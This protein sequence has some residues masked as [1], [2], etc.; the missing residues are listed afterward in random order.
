MVEI[1]KNTLYLTSA[2]TFQKILAFFYFALI[3]R[4]LDPD[5]VGK[6]VFALSFV[7][8]FSIF[9]DLG[10]NPVLV[11]EIARKEEKSNFYLNN[12]ITLK[13]ILSFLVYFLLFIVINLLKYPAVTKNLVYIAGL[14]MLFDSFALTFFAVF[15]GLRNLTYESLAIIIYQILLVSIGTIFLIL[16]RSV[17]Y[18]ILIYFLVT[19]FYFLI[20][21]IL[22]YKK[23]LFRIR[24]F[25]KKDILLYLFSISPAFFLANFLNRIYYGLDVV[26]ISKLVTDEAVG[27]YSVS[28]KLVLALIFLPAALGAAIFPAFSNLYLTSREKLN[29][30]FQKSFFYLFILSFPIMLGTISLAKEI[31]AEVYGSVYFPS[32]L[33]LKILISSVVFLFLNFSLGAL[34][35]ACERQYLQTRNMAIATF[36]NVFLNFLLIP[37]YSF[38]GASIA[39]VVSEALLF[40]L[41][42]FQAN[43]IIRWNK[44]YLLEKFSK[45]IFSALIMIILIF[46]LKPYL[47]IIFLIPLAGFLYFFILYLTRGIKREELKI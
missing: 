15:R 17:F 18:L 12:I 10:L 25:L 22:V 9:L 33:P 16:L 26:L 13:L 8:I 27:Y 20:S 46:C 45:V 28:R 41:G 19:F 32:I 38:I 2:Y 5:S 24:L 30:I 21:L 43:K 35:N 6:Y 44:T 23:T 31:I 39:L 7:T 47:R 3:A 36:A 11:R 34:L 37:P 4:F 1:K 14:A 42:L 29:Q 40:F